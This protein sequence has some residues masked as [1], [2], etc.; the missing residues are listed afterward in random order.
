MP[1]SARIDIP[2]LL[3]HV[4]CRGNEKRDIFTDDE[5]RRRF[6]K[7]FSNLLVSTDTECFAWALLSNHFHLLLRP[8]Q[9]SLGNFMKRLLTGYAVTFNLRHGRSGH[10][11]QNRYKSIVCDEE[12]YLLE[13]VRYIHLNPLRAGIVSSIDELGQY[14]WSGHSVLL[15]NGGLPGQVT[16]EVLARFGKSVGDSRLH[17]RSFIEDG[18]AMG[19]RNDLAGS[20]KE[21]SRENLEAMQG[22]LVLGDEN[23]V[24]QLLIQTEVEPTPKRMPLEAI[25]QGVCGYL[26]LS[27]TDLVSK[28]RTRSIASA[29]CLICHIAMANGHRGIDVANRLGITPS[30]VTL[31][32][33]RG[34]KTISDHPDLARICDLPSPSGHSNQS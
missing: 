33:H 31:A 8:R 30:G 4:I 22:T 17:Y 13:L 5:D 10:L 19:Q 2:N 34:A 18:I 3:Q 11:F 21:G 29:R 12:G 14:A 20:R 26:G 24:A 1:R 28:S 25:L 15:G 27:P 6:V 9:T 32:A 16:E 23:F 7:R